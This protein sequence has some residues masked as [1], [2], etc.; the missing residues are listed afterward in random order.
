MGKANL[1]RQLRQ[2]IDRIWLETAKRSGIRA[3]DK[4]IIRIAEVV[5][6]LGDQ[7]EIGVSG[8][9]RGR[10]VRRFLAGDYWIYY[11]GGAGG[12]R[13]RKL[14]HYKQDQSKDWDATTG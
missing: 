12:A 10:E 9:R 11:E 6:L 14:K 13:I 3:A 7:P 8:T 4:T 5:A 2:Q 1:S